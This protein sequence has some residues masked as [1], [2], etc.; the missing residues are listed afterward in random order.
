MKY[1]YVHHIIGVDNLKVT[2]IVLTAGNSTRFNKNSN[3]NLEK[4]KDKYIFEYSLEQFE[5]NSFIDEIIIAVK[6][7]EKEKIQNILKNKKRL[8]PINLIVGGK[9][10]KDSV[11]N[12]L[13]NTNSDVVI[14]HDGARPLIK[15]EYIEN[16]I[17]TME[18]F[19][20]TSIAVKAKD[21][22]KICNE[23]NIVESTTKRENTWI[24]QTPQCFKREKLLEAHSKFK[25]NKEITDDC[26]LLELLGEKVKLIQ[27]D[28]TNIKITTPED[29]DL[30]EKFLIR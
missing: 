21:T 27:G 10:R 24:I 30:V 2:A 26:M 13:T 15:Q 25:N 28:Y 7:D 6:Q 19:K 5:R 9:T 16:C 3:K 22:I 4:I 23:N 29:I 11:Y 17:K 20:G 18:E 1:I 14:I 12:C 8:K